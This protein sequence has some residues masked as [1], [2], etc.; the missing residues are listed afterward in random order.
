MNDTVSTIIVDD[1]EP[2]RELLRAF[3]R[4]WPAIEI[5]GEAGDGRS[6]MKLIDAHRPKLIFFDV[7]MP[8]MT[9]LDVASS[10]EV[11]PPP[12]IVFVTAHDQYAVRAFEV[13]AVDYV[14]KPF[15]RPRFRKMMERV[16]SRLEEKGVPSPPWSEILRLAANAP[17]QSVV[18]KVDGRH[19]FLDPNDIEWIEAVAKDVQLHLAT[20][21]GTQTILAKESMQSLETRLDPNVFVRVHRST[22]VNRRQ[23]REIQSWFRG[24][25]VL[26]LRRGAR[27]VSGPTYR[28]AVQALLRGAR[29]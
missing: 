29:L 10:L 20:G 7:Q 11:N 17:Q 14:L 25:Y 13:S 22:I 12:L 6:A 27:V 4:E 19:I 2:S 5:V 23:I 8:G 26:I 15:N 16:L 3:L 9:G 1:E 28:A 18:V 24:D 21:S